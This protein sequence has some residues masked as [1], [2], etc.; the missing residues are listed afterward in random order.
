MEIYIIV[1]DEEQE[2]K[3]KYVKS[4]KEVSI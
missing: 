3:E 1:D 4:W 2:L